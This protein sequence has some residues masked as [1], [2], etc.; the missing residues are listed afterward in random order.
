VLVTG[1]TGPMHMAVAVGTP[2]VGL[3]FGPASPF[4]TGPY[5]PDNVLL[6]ATAPCA[7]CDHNVTCLRPFCR[8]EL[9]P[10]AVAAA[11]AARLVDDWDALDGLARTTAGARLYRTTFDADGRYRCDPLGG[12]AA[13]HEDALRA[14][15]RATSL[16]LLARAPLPE[17]QATGIDVR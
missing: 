13:R 5:A 2:V 7:P 12:V 14:A 1:D 9:P 8:D 17:P 10:D 6:H 3:F 11:V 4:D 15:Y 16:A